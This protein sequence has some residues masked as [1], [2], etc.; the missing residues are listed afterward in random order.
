MASMNAGRLFE[1]GS[2]RLV[3]GLIVAVA[4]A[5]GV[6]LAVAP[7][8]PG[9][10]GLEVALVGSGLTGAAAVLV[11][12]VLRSALRQAALA[13]VDAPSVSSRTPSRP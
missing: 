7:A 9:P 4:V 2:L 1:A 11:L 13:L 8:V 10:P 3:D 12:I 6:V 5:A